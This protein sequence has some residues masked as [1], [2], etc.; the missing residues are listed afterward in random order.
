[1][2][3]VH[4]IRA[5]SGGYRFIIRNQYT[6][7]E[8]EVAIDP[9]KLGLFEDRSLLRDLPEACPFLRKNPVDQKAYCTVHLTRPD[10]CREFSCWRLLILDAKGKRAGRIMYRRYL[11]PEDE[12]LKKVWDECIDALNEPDDDA[13]DAEMI[14]ILMRAGYRVVR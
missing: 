7:E 4:S 9:D 10:I 6:G 13:W 11:S 12:T 8:K 14:R 3:L 2:G 5:D 1:M